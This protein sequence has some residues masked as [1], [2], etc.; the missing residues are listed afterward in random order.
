MCYGAQS[1]GRR[2]GTTVG[3]LAYWS[4]ECCGF[5][6]FFLFNFSFKKYPKCSHS[7]RTAHVHMYTWSVSKLWIPSTAAWSKLAFIMT[8][9]WYLLCTYIGYDLCLKN[10]VQYI[11]AGRTAVRVHTECSH[12]ASTLTLACKWRHL[13]AFRKVKQYLLES[14]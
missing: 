5:E 1:I 6:Y 10:I 8:Y 2:W 4:W 7:D 14:T 11:T 3:V 9:K 13:T 12:L